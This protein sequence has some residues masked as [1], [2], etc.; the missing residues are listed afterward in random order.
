MLGVKYQKGRCLET[1]EHGEKPR[2]RQG[3]GLVQIQ[4]QRQEVPRAYPAQAVQGGFVKGWLVVS[5]CF[6]RGERAGS[7]VEQKNGQHMSIEG[8]VLAYL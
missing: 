8:Q 1:C 2:T 3:S 7:E 5:S 4:T 6:W